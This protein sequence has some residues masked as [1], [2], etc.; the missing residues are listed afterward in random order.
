MAERGGWKPDPDDHEIPVLQERAGGQVMGGRVD[1]F[2]LCT[3]TCY[4]V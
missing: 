4:N 2:C 3:V 1:R